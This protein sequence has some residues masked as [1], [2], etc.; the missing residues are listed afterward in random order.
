MM[1]FSATSIPG[2]SHGPWQSLGVVV[3]MVLAELARI[4]AEIQQEL[5]KRRGAGPQIRWTAWELPGDHPLAGGYM[6]VK[7]ALRPEV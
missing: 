7:N 5:G 4:V 6:P 1:T 3:E 2:R